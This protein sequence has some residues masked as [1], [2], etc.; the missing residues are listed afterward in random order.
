[1]PSTS[2]GGWAD[3]AMSARPRIPK[4]SA[5]EAAFG[6]RAT[7]HFA[8][9]LKA[10]FIPF[11]LSG[12]ILANGRYI[13][14]VTNIDHNSI[15]FW[16]WPF[17]GIYL[18]QFVY[19]PYSSSDI[20][21]FFTVVSCSNLVWLIFLVWKLAF[22]LFRRDV[23][24]PPG[25]APIIDQLIVRVLAVSGFILVVF[26]FVCFWGFHSEGDAIFGLY[27]KQSIAAGAIKMVMV[28]MFGLYVGAA[29]FLEFGGLGLRYVLFRVFG[30][31]AAEPTYLSKGEN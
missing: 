14:Q 23:K 30:W 1:M 25:K 22:E 6:H 2:T 28:L 7:R 8:I 29:F 19:S 18:R 17:N 21:W 20:S 15:V 13:S 5:G 27:F 12:F 10:L 24:F 31:F 26:I 11:T 4:L 3:A 9:G 16:L